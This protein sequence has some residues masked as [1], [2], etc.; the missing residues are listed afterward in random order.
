MAQTMPE[1]D[2]LHT[3]RGESWPVLLCLI[4]LLGLY[5]TIFA[6]WFLTTKLGEKMAWSRNTNCR[7]VGA[8]KFDSTYECLEREREREREHAQAQA[9]E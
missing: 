8:V 4:L 2:T 6:D 3:A 5:T 9:W 1:P 7:I